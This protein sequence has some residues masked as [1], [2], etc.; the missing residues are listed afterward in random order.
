MSQIQDIQ[1]LNLED[2]MGDRFGRYSKYIIQDRA[3]PDIRDGLKPVNVVFY[4]RC[5]SMETQAI[6]NSVNQ[7]RLS[8]T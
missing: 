3:L 5:L 7:L 2:V 6:N 4:M 1:E 8:V